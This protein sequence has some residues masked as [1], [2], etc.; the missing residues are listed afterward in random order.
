MTATS[1]THE[2]NLE[3]H[4]SDEEG[5]GVGDLVSMTDKGQG[6][7]PRRIQPR[8]IIMAQCSEPAPRRVIQTVPPAR[9]RP[10][11]KSSN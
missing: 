7:P 3:W 11:N 2:P 10:R 9:R 4:S 6:L 8:R 5:E 1:Q